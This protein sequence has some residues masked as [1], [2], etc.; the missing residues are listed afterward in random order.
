MHLQ[1]S[2]YIRGPTGRTKALIIYLLERPVYDRVI[3]LKR[4]SYVCA[5]RN[6]FDIAG[7]NIVCNDSGSYISAYKTIR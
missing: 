5:S 3:N 2:I 7:W 1:A 4:V 6:V